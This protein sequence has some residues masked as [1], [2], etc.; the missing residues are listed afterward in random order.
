MKLSSPAVWE[1]LTYLICIVV[2]G[3]YTVAIP[4]GEAPDEPGHYQCILQV[5]VDNR[6]PRVEPEP[7][8]VWYGRD[9]V[10]SGYICYH[11]PLYYL[12][13]GVVYRI[14]VLM[15]GDSAI[16]VF[17]ESTGSWGD[18]TAMFRQS[19]DDAGLLAR[20]PGVWGALSIGVIST[21]MLLAA[22]QRLARLWSPRLPWV[23]PLAG[24]L[25]ACWPQLAFMGRSL[26]NDM[27]AAALA[28]WAMLIPAEAPS[29]RRY[30]LGTLL[31]CLATLTKL[32]VAFVVAVLFCQFLY[33]LVTGQHHARAR[34]EA[35]WTVV[36]MVGL[37]AGTSALIRFHPVLGA[38]LTRALSGYNTVGSAAWTWSYWFDVFS[39]TLS[40]GF[41]RFGWMNVAPSQ[42]ISVAWWMTMALMG[43]IGLSMAW[44]QGS[45]S[46]RLLLLI[47]LWFLGALAVYLRINLDRFQPQ[48][49]F[50]FA[51][52]PLIA[53]VVAGGLVQ[54]SRRWPISPQRMMVAA[55][56][57]L[58]LLNGWL[59]L[60]V[61]AP[62]YATLG[63]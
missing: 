11:M 35:I 56:A 33:D 53:V 48:F 29:G 46:K 13:T 44:R 34:R 27:L 59:V 54:L 47:F 41:A 43:A 57:I 15:T 30:V 32:T 49:R 51:V 31:A 14:A 5:A 2:I 25:I 28:V 52:L 9:S 4:F 23:A 42:P 36:V 17:P 24:L 38:H 3:A 12:A 6:L 18:R 10:L 58:L 60:T 62:T 19:V 7:S 8:G 50:M 55:A 16:Y 20:P 63:S 61:V 45:V 40:S 22:T 39:L 21:L 26:S 1:R 37:V